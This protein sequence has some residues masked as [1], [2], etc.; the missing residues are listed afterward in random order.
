NLPPRP[1]PKAPAAPTSPSATARGT[2]AGSRPA[3]AVP[4]NK[5]GSY[6]PA[7]A[8]SLPPSARV[9]PVSDDDEPDVG[10]WVTTGL[11]WL[12]L[13]VGLLFAGYILIRPFWPA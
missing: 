8:P 5:P 13:I 9:A 6:S 11:F 12:V 7:A 4:S 2:L 1:S 3:V 10:A